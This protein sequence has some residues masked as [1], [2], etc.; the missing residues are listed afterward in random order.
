MKWRIPADLE[1][2]SQDR[3]AQ[4]GLD[5]GR[6]PARGHAIRARVGQGMV[7]FVS[8]VL[9]GATLPPNRIAGHPALDQE[10]P[11]IIAYSFKASR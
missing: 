6:V 9:S 11:V 2:R 10:G 7:P 8:V 3:R 1:F 4:A 5:A